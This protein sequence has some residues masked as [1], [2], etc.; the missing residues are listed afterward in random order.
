MSY[1]VVSGEATLFTFTVAY[2][3]FH[4]DVPTPFVVALVELVEQSGLRLITNIV[5]C[6]PDELVCGMP[7]RV[8][9]ERHDHR[10]EPMYV[11]VF[12]PAAPLTW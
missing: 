8:R 6:D 1:A 10:G 5:D 12:T 7:L 9:F 2:Q 3:Q 11:P 4:P